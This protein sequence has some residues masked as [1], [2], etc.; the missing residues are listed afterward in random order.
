MFRELSRIKQKLTLNECEQ[1][2][3]NSKRGVLS[4][5][6]ENGFPYGVP[7]NHF[8]NKEDKSIYFHCGKKGYRLDCIKSDKRA[9]FCLTDGGVLSQN[10][11]SYDF[12]S[13]VVFGEIEIIED[14]EVVSDITKKLSQKFTNDNGYIEKEIK[15][16]LK[17]TILLKL[18]PL[19]VCGKKVKEQ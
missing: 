13:V 16:Y 12:K 18:T 17:S 8:Y 3:I 6:G 9:C 2:L 19:H 10:G 5:N 14:L 1:I 4:V 11:W 15:E 7:I